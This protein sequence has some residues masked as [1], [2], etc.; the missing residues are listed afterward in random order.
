MSDVCVT[1]PKWKW[2]E[3]IGEGDTLGVDGSEAPAAWEGR[4]EYGF[5]L[6]T[7]PNIARGE[8]VYIVAHGRLRG[9]SPLVYIDCTTPERF[10]RG[11]CALVR[12]GGGVAVTIPERVRGFQG[13]Q[14]R[15]WDRA[16]EEPFPG[17]RTIDVRP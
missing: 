2:A 11:V 15:W 5:G 12:E 10:G 6:P 13:Y 8:R 4:Y 1:V 16:D 7:V 9:Y 17:W 3:W 14:Y